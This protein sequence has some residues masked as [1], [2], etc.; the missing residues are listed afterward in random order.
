MPYLDNGSAKIQKSKTAPLAKKVAATVV[1]ALAIGFGVS[2]CTPDPIIEVQTSYVTVTSSTT[3]TRSFTATETE[4]LE[5]EETVAEAVTP[6]AA[7]ESG[8]GTSSGV[9]PMQAAPAA[10]PPVQSSYYANCSAARS[11]G[12]APLYVGQPGYRS[13]LDRDNDGIACE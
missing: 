12:A 11:A 10:Q 1:T 3:V 13:G 8:Y 6:A 5:P 2:G 9:E 4:T 7:T